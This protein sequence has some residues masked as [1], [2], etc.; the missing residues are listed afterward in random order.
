MADDSRADPLD[1]FPTMMTPA[2]VAE[3]VQV[4][5]VRLAA[6]RG[7]KVGPPWVKVGDGPNGAVRYPRED[8]RRYIEARTVR[9]ADDTAA[10]VAS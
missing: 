2:D 9:P 7:K 4:S 6:W 3:Y 8:L 5:E 10:A 1:G